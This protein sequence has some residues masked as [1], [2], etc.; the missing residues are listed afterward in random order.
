MTRSRSMLGLAGWTLG[1]LAAGGLGSVATARSVG[2]WYV[3]I[4]KPEWTPPGVVFGP[5]WTTLYVM[6]GVAAWQVWRAWS[7]ED[8]PTALGAFVGQLLLNALWSFLFFGL[9]GPGWAAVEIVV[10]WFA[11]AATI[12]LFYRIRRTAAL[13]LV[14]YLAWVSYATALNIAIWNLNRGS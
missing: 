6:M 4:A 8:R 1:C 3:D 10:L 12:V 9:R 13:L 7:R 14:P 5:V 11:I 2:S